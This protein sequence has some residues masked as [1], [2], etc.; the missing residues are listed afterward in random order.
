[1]KNIQKI[2]LLI[3]VVLA[4]GSVGVWSELKAAPQAAP[5]ANP[6]NRSGQM[7]V[8]TVVPFPP[9]LEISIDEISGSISDNGDGTATVQVFKDTFIAHDCGGGIGCFYFEN[10]GTS[11]GGFD[12][13]NVSYSQTVDI[14]PGAS[15]HQ[16]GSGIGNAT[17]AGTSFDWN[18]F[19]ETPVM[20]SFQ[21]TIQGANEDVSSFNNH[22]LD[23]HA[24][25][26]TGQVTT[27][28]VLSRGTEASGST[29][30]SASMSV[31][32][33]PY[34]NAAGIYGQVQAFTNHTVTRI[35]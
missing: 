28:R 18:T 13:A 32:G 17:L 25:P 15:G 1:M 7:T 30:A 10:I 19:T 27:T 29:A 9:P 31:D 6:P 33:S 34:Y 35:H 12:P 23:V 21:A 5:Q 20:I 22:T 16:I 24:D 3:A 14:R 11:V 4:A 2:G 8:F 26:F